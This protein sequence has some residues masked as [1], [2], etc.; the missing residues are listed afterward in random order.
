MKL[1]NQHLDPWSR[2]SRSS[3]I[4]SSYLLVFLSNYLCDVRCA[5]WSLSCEK[6]TSGSASCKAPTDKPWQSGHLLIGHPSDPAYPN[7]DWNHRKCSSTVKTRCQHGSNV[8]VR[9]GAGG[10]CR[11]GGK[12]A[13]SMVLKILSGDMGGKSASLEE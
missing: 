8:E 4:F 6:I 5:M 11:R 9:M 2:T 1:A 10:Q 3:N 7:K 12:E 13:M